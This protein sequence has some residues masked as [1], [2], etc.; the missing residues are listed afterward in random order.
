MSI[1]KIKSN[2]SARATLH[3]ALSK[4]GASV[5]GGAVAPWVER[6]LLD[7]Q[8]LGEI[9]RNATREFMVSINQNQRVKRAIGHTSISFAARE[10]LDDEQMMDYCEQYLAAMI[11]TAQKPAL[12]K[13]LEEQTFRAAV[14]AFRDN[15]LHKYSYTIVRHTD[16]DHPHAHIVYSRINLESEQAVSTSFERYRSQA[17]LRDL[18]RQYELEVLPNSW[19][20]GRRAASISQMEVET[21]TG[22]LSVQQRLQAI[23]EQAGTASKTLLE[24]IRAVQARGIQVR[25]GF[26]R[27]GKSKGI[28]YSLDG[29]ALA[30]NALGTRYSFKHDDP[31]LC[32][33]FGL[34]Y[35]AKRDN[36]M[37]QSLCQNQPLSQS[38]EEAETGQ[39]VSIES[40]T[41]LA[42][43]DLVLSTRG[44]SESEVILVASIESRGINADKA[45]AA[46]SELSDGAFSAGDLGAPTGGGAESEGIQ[47]GGI[48]AD[49]AASVAAD[50]VVASPVDV[51][52]EALPKE[53]IAPMPVADADTLMQP[54][55]PVKAS[56][57]V[58]ATH[59]QANV[60]GSSAPP[61]E[62]SAETDLVEPVVLV[63]PGLIASVPVAQDSP[64]QWISAASAGET[65]P[66]QALT[67]M[68]STQQ[69]VE[70]AEQITRIL[71]T[72]FD[73]SHQF[74]GRYDFSAVKE[75]YNVTLDE[76]GRLT[77]L[78]VDGQALI[79]QDKP[80]AGLEQQ[81]WEF[82]KAWRVE[83]MRQEQ[84]QRA[85]VQPAGK[86][87]QQRRMDGR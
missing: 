73:L 9:V 75:K 48:K 79:N 68:A 10:Q 80:T 2:N 28:S 3:Y 71:K 64:P 16:Q 85:S 83:L 52:A 47:V 82:F 42:A 43:D 11:L 24:Y 12:L 65:N 13:P 44:V 66:A 38:V 54:V 4:K 5:I 45:V 23:L 30:G 17:I 32:R 62:Q 61:P 69:Q 19:E 87:P 29:V 46:P 53:L 22:K 70:Q 37:I 35:Q 51:L 6:D 56:E 58:E 39:V 15:E 49:L 78:R 50:S 67:K 27:T 59:R 21:E 72:A 84:R 41:M 34:E 18:E 31:G 76:A 55:K 74:P 86:K 25:V 81:D 26:T 60:V 57:F 20:V 77:L 8:Q 63:Q 40:A 7:K 36:A 14:K 33:A 1:A